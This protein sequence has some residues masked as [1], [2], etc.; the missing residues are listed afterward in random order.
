MTEGTRNC[1]Y[2]FS[3]YDD[4]E[5]VGVSATYKFRYER[6][7]LALIGAEVTAGSEEHRHHG[8]MASTSRSRS[9]R[10]APVGSRVGGQRGGVQEPPGA[11][12]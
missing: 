6:G 10:I 1:S 3:S 7:T 12:N 8:S 5:V 11:R 4:P 9:A 2:P